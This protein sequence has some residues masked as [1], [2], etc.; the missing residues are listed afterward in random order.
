MMKKVH[1]STNHDYDTIFTQIMIK[2]YFFTIQGA[3][4]CL[5]Q[6]LTPVIRFLVQI[7]RETEKVS[8]LEY[9]K[10]HSMYFSLSFMHFCT[11]KTSQV[12]GH[13]QVLSSLPPSSSLSS[14]SSA[15]SSQWLKDLQRHIPVNSCARVEINAV[16]PV[17]DNVKESD[18][19]DLSG[20]F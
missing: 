14:S 18:V 6:G 1:F 8:S 19:D 17:I 5:V 10:Y 20:R 9:L 2:V 7:K 3:P 15:S 4:T 13:H 11:F 16:L 12:S